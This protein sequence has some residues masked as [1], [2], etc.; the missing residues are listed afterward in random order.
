MIELFFVVVF[1][2]LLIVVFYRRVRRG[3]FV[4][5]VIAR[6]LSCCLDVY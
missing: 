6:F 1:V 4:D 2:V 3:A 5:D